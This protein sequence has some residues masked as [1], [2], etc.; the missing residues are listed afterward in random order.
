MEQEPV[1]AKSLK[2]SSARRFLLVLSGF[3]VAVNL[4]V[5]LDIPILR[6]I[7]GLPF[8][9]VL[10]GLLVLF[11]LKLDK[12]ETPEKIVLTIGLS[13][14][15]LMLFGWNFSQICV[16][17]GYDRPLDTNTIVPAL[18][19]ALFILALGAY[20]RNR[21]AFSAFPFKFELNASGKL[22]L[23][24]PAFLPLLSIL[25]M[26]HLNSSGSN[27]ILVVFFFLVSV[28][29]IVLFFTRRY[30]SRDTYPVALILISFALLS[31]FWMRS[32]HVFGVDIHKEFY[33]FHVTHVNAHWDVFLENSSLDSCLSISILPALFQSVFDVNWEEYLFKGIYVFIC[34]FTPLTIYI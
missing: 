6:E 15:F 11:L 24:L 22:V 34:T 13:V 8:L 33:L 18:S 31:V 1:N 14:G 9:I 28:A 16:G 27:T 20:L 29:I 30:I 4:V 17:L 5:L 3:L 12:L 19:A 21:E 7:L 32:E 2:L 10:P 26:R 25:G 23:L